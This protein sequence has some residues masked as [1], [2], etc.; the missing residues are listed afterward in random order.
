MEVSMNS[1]VAKQ[2]I[3]KCFQTLADEQLQQ[4]HLTHDY[5]TGRR[6]NANQLPRMSESDVDAAIQKKQRNL[7]C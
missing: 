7:S 6:L 2:T 1:E 4:Y 5:F 3:K